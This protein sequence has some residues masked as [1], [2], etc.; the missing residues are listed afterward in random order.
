MPKP[1]PALTAKHLLDSIGFADSSQLDI[2]ELIEYH[3]GIV[4]E[5]PL[6]NADGRIVIKGS[7]SIVT[8]N[9]NIEY[10]LKKRFVLAHELG[11]LLLHKED[12]ISFSDDYRTLE[13]MR[14]GTQ[15]AE[16]NEFATE[17]LMPTIEFFKFIYLKK[18]T[19]GLLRELAEKFQ[20]SITSI[21][22]RYIDIGHHPICVFYSKDG[23]LL[24]WKRS[25]KFPYYIG[26]KNGLPVPIDSVAQEYFQSK[27]I[28]S[29]EEST[30]EIRKSTWFELGEY[31]RNDPVMFE[32]CIVTKKHNT[33]LSVVWGS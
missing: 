11:H 22:Y 25:Q 4:V 1:H 20:T 17:L 16:A 32:Y 7:N 15:E 3:N 24:Y 9:S 33:V 18:F 12:C 29:K 26:D 14:S 10:P 13:A 5:R 30:Q 8:V 31:D 28:Y 21:V 23:K 19:P 2:K 6:K 27:K